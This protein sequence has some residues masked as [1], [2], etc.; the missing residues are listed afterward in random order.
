MLISIKQPMQI[1]EVIT[2]EE[3]AKESVSEPESTI[4]LESEKSQEGNRN[5]MEEVIMED[6]IENDRDG[7]ECQKMLGDR[8][9][10]S[11][12]KQKRDKIWRKENGRTVLRS[13]EK[14]VN[15]SLSDSDI[16][17]RRKTRSA[18]AKDSKR[19]NKAPMQQQETK[20][21]V[22]SGDLIRRIWGDD[23]FDFRYA[24]AMNK[25]YCVNRFVLVEGNWLSKGWEG[26]LINVYTP[27]TLMEQK[28]LSEEMIEVRKQFTNHWIVGGDFNRVSNRSKRSNCVGLLKGSKDFGSFIDKCKLVDLP[29]M[30]KKFTWYGTEKKRSRLDRFL[31]DEEWLEHFEDL[32][33][34]GLKR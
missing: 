23:N 16:S 17:N 21:E 15:L 34:Q 28:I 14:I 18:V 19:T 20:L 32:Q 6:G 25:E 12:E 33:Q 26:I 9:L 8:V 4:G 2:L 5:V 24:V 11:K 7:K 13:E 30:G 1:E 22:V 31:V 10:T 29:L 27:S 3:E